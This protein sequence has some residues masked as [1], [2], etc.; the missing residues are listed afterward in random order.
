MGKLINYSVLCTKRIILDPLLKT[1]LVVKIKCM[2]T[3]KAF[4]LWLGNIVKCLLQLVLF[5]GQSSKLQQ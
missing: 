4:S 2:A 5:E 1:R 3:C